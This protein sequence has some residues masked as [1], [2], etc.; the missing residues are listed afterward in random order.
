M[1]RWA[2]LRRNRTKALS[3]SSA[4]APPFHGGGGVGAR[5]SPAKSAMGEFDLMAVPV[6]TGMGEGHD[7]ARQAFVVNA[8]ISSREPPPLRRINTSS[9]RTAAVNRSAV[10]ISAA[11]LRALAA[12]VDQQLRPPETSSQH[13]QNG[14][15]A[16]SGG[17]VMMRFAREGSATG[18]CAPQR[19][20][21]RFDLRSTPRIGR[22]TNRACVI[23]V[24]ADE[25]V[26]AARLVQ[27][28]RALTS[29]FW[30]SLAVK[31]HNYFAAGT[32]R[33][34]NLAVGSLSEKYQWPG[35]GSRELGFRL[36]SKGARNPR[37]STL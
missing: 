17:E 20:G 37:S 25:L 16:A 8:Q 15:V 13:L 32:W 35:A 11:G 4:S 26:L 12:P 29:T 23:H 7:G 24:I 31:G 3:H 30:P 6:I 33:Q 18:S 21:F 36:P 14:A 22:S 27:S 28:D 9:F 10:T 2:K 34:A 19:T 1:E 5:T